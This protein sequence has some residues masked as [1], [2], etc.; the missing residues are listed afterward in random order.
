[1]A[2]SV[3]ATFFAGYNLISLRR[4]NKTLPVPLNI[5]IDIV[6]LLPL[7]SLISDMGDVR[8]PCDDWHYPREP[9]VDLG[10]CWAFARAVAP[11]LWSFLIL[12]LL[13]W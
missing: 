5:V 10:A 13:L 2:Q 11:I 7:A 12:S 4:T 1:M 6:L 3:L 8:F 9:R